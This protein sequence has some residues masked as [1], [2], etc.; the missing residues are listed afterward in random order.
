MDRDKKRKKDG[1]KDGFIV[2]FAPNGRK[3]ALSGQFLLLARGCEVRRNW[4]RSA[5]K[6]PR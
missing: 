1:K 3:R 4:S 2:F 6:R 5:P